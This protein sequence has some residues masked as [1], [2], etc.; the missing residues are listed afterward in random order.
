MTSKLRSPSSLLSKKEPSNPEYRS[1]QLFRGGS[2]ENL[3]LAGVEYSAL[4]TPAHQ[5]H[6]V[7][8]ALSHHVLRVTSGTQQH[9]VHPAIMHLK[10]MSLRVLF[11]T[12]ATPEVETL[13]RVKWLNWFLSSVWPLHNHDCI[14]RQCDHYTIMTA[15]LFHRRRC[16][17]CG[18][19]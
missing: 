5:C 17:S 3:C 15:F 12:A 14:C 4:G 19:C 16:C 8:Q 1:S 13:L 11:R 6:A 9:F 7:G 18:G 10:W 2:L